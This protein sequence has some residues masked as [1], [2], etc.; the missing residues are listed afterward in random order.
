MAR[1]VRQM[2][3][4]VVI[5]AQKLQLI[6]SRDSAAFSASLQTGSHHDLG[7]VGCGVASLTIIAKIA[8]VD[9]LILMA[10]DACGRHVS[11]F[12]ILFVA[13]GADEPLVS[14]CEGEAGFIIMVETPGFPA[15]HRVAFRA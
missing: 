4:F 11:W 10:R 14:P 1:L 9:V 6:D 7:K 2:I 15:R 3:H 12:D 8:V 13:R 5:Y